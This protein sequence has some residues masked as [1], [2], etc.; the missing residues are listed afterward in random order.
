MLNI[1]SDESIQGRRD[2]EEKREEMAEALNDDIKRLDRVV[3]DAEDIIKSLGLVDS[4]FDLE[5]AHAKMFDF[6]KEVEVTKIEIK[7]KLAALSAGRVGL[8]V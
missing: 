5:S 7:K 6:I 3:R 8:L 1:L 4:D 2:E